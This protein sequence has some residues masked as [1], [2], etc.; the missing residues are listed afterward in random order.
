MNTPWINS[1]GLTQIQSKQPNRYTAGFSHDARLLQKADDDTEHH[2]SYIK[3]IE[4]DDLEKN[5]RTIESLS[6]AD[7]A[8][9]EIKRRK[10]ECLISV[11]KTIQL[12]SVNR[13]T[14][15]LKNHQSVETVNREKEKRTKKDN[16]SFLSM[17]GEKI[18]K[19][20]MRHHFQVVA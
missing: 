16:L 6:I 11:L 20:I 3:T 2:K 5:K 1:D 19:N 15:I 9:L 10:L 18:K 13:L 8:E 4:F 17:N 14:K 12:Q 7:D